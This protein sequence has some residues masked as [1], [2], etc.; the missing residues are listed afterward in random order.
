MLCDQLKDWLF[1]IYTGEM[2]TVTSLP[3]SKG[4]G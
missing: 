1:Y 3:E 2:E 4:V